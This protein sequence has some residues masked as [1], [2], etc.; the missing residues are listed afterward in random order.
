MYFLRNEFLLFFV[1]NEY[2]DSLR[3]LLAKNV[4]NCPTNMNNNFFKFLRLRNDGLRSTS[5]RLLPK[6]RKK[7]QKAL[8][9]GQRPGL[10]WCAANAL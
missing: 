8:S 5:G 7:G 10:I 1:R 4:N 9:P 3:A 6:G 2:E